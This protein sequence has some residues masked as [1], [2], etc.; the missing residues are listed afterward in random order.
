ML[1]LMA[2][3][4]SKQHLMC[5]HLQKHVWK[6]LGEI[7]IT[8]CLCCAVSY[9]FLIGDTLW[10]TQQLVQIFA[11]LF[12]T[13]IL[14]FLFDTLEISLISTVRLNT[15]PSCF[16]L[17]YCILSLQIDSCFLLSL[18]MSSLPQS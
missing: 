7:P 11:A 16:I 17:T 14:V 13:S 2:L 9:L 6:V 4:Y 3:T 5:I 15:I 8:C 12:S 1:G 10:D 18:A